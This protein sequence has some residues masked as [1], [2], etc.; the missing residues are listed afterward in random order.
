MS[1][2]TGKLHLYN[3]DDYQEIHLISKGKI[4]IRNEKT[5]GKI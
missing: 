4:Q 1:A 5:A 2:V 3:L